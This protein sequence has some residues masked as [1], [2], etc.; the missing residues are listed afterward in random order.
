MYTPGA[1]L[2]NSE[3]GGHKF[4]VQYLCAVGKVPYTLLSCSQNYDQLS[5]GRGMN[6]SRETD[7]TQGLT[8]QAKIMYR[9]VFVPFRLM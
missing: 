6:V 1:Q 5:R 9:P 2:E 3:G 7:R 4:C 8:S